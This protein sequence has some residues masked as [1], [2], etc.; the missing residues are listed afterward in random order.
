MEDILWCLKMNDVEHKENYPLSEISA[1]RIGGKA[2]LVVYPKSEKELICLVNRLLEKEIKFKILGRMSNV[3]PSDEGYRGVV[4]RT[5]RLKEYAIEGEVATVASG[6]GIP[7]LAAKT[8]ELG[9]S[10]LE[11]LSGIPCSL[12]GAIFGN[13]GAFGR[14]MGD[15]IRSVRAFSI[16]EGKIIDFSVEKCIFSYR[17][18]IF[19]SGEHVILSAVL[20][21]LK[22]DENTVKESIHKY[23]KMRLDTQPHGLLSLGSTFK[24]PQGDSAGRM[25]DECGLKG[26]TI[27]GAQISEKHAGFIVNIGNASAEDYKNLAE[28][29]QGAVYQRFG[30]RLEY[31]I[32]EI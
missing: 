8:A 10:G 6:V 28:Y 5:D 26:Y 9:L 32:E 3:L 18:S 4:I 17:S 12:G 19:K 2:D 7:Y 20:K 31:E 15:L 16:R 30:T 24:R 29:A 1:I 22:S 27:G 21:F 25:I 13:A 14:E 11:Q 23:R